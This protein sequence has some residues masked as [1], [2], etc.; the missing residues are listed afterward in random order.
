MLYLGCIILVENNNLFFA[1]F[2]VR[3]IHN[4]YVL[5]ELYMRGLFL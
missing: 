2:I 4:G 3:Q 1:N 5:Y